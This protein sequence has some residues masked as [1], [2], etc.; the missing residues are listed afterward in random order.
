MNIVH[1]ISNKVWGGGEQYALDLCRR[2]SA[3]GNKVSVVTKN[4]E[5]VKRP[6]L[7]SGID[8]AVMPLRGVIDLVS[9]WRLAKVLRRAEGGEAVVH[10]HNFKDAFTA[11]YARKLVWGKKVRIVVTRHLVRPAKT[12][13]LYRWLFRQ[14]D[15]LIFVSKLARDSFMS[16]LPDVDESRISVIHNS[17]TLPEN[18]SAINLHQLYSIDERRVIAMYHGRLSAEKGID[19]LLE[20]MKQLRKEK[21]HLVLVGTGDEKY[22]KKL[23]KRLKKLRIADNVTLAGFQD[24]IFRYIAG[25][26]MGIVPTVAQEAFGLSCLEYM[27]MRKPVVTTLNGA[28]K[29]FIDN[30]FNG[31]LVEPDNAEAL[32]QKIKML[33]DN[34]E[35]RRVIGD[36]ALQTM[37]TKLNYEDFYTRIKQQYLL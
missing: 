21:L 15:S 19:T 33:A 6:F 12:S 13:S 8:L 24:E 27:A 10:V 14:I 26:D 2:L 4:Y 29:E 3:D 9:A 18:T 1:L 25:C 16:S 17:I 22:M 20:A 7:A 23:G 30:G 34:A 11:A 36:N 31:L 37:R 28:Q 35:M 32:A 5:A